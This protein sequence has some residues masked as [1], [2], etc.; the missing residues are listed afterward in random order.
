M[1]SY[2]KKCDLFPLH[3]TYTHQAEIRTILKGSF[4]AETGKNL[5]FF[6][7]LNQELLFS[8][9]A[10]IHLQ[11]ILSPLTLFFFSRDCTNNSMEHCCA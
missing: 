5:L 8:K 9:C 7:F 6:L 2:T 10:Q 3:L 1:A 11:Q 4:A